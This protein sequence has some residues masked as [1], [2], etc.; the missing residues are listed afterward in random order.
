MGFYVYISN[1]TKREDGHLC[2]HDKNYTTATIPA[3]AN[4][5]CPFHGQY[6]IYYNERPVKDSYTTGH[7]LNAIIELCEV[8]VYGCTSLRRYGSDCSKACPKNCKEYCHIESGNCLQCSSGYRGE[9]C[10]QE[11]APGFHGED[12]LLTCGKCKSSNKCNPINGSCEHGCI[13]GYGGLLCN[14]EN[15]AY[16]HP[17]WQSSSFETKVG[18]SKAVDGLKDDFSHVGYQ[19]SI[20]ANGRRQATWLVNLSGIRSI[21]NVIMYY[22]TGNILW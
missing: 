1:T 17:T 13:A 7:S 14:D 4:I 3:I 16:N 10:E 6:V 9:R 15:M 19:C 12:C 21:R 22:R 8:E 20:S 2:F 18:S 5:T 11:C